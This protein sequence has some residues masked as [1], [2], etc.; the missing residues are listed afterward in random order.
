MSDAKVVGLHGYEPPIAGAQVSVIEKLETLLAEARRGEITAFAMVAIRPNM[1]IGS[2]STRTK[3]YRHLM[4][5]GAAYLMH[6]LCEEK[7][8]E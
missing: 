1:E 7:G 6:D 2:I 3:G 4:L 8:E 5:A